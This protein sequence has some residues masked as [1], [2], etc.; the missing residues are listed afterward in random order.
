[1]AGDIYYWIRNIVWYSY[2]RN[3]MII[4]SFFVK[5]WYCTKDN[6]IT[7]H[8]TE[9]RMNRLYGFFKKSTIQHPLLWNI[10]GVVFSLLRKSWQNIS[11]MLKSS[12]R[13]K[14][15]ML[16]LPSGIITCHSLT[17]PLP[18]IIFSSTI[19]VALCP[20]IVST[21]NLRF[22]FCINE[23]ST[24]ISIGFTDN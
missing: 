24:I 13:Q 19:M 23:R 15:L 18:I 9:I 20:E 14:R 6:R 10:N 4:Y 1:M 7:F 11:V 2:L 5:D 22:S 21:S 12:I 8:T 17:H 16:E 3:T